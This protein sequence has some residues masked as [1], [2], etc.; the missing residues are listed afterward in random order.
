MRRALAGG[1]FAAA[2]AVAF[3]PWPLR[4]LA[5]FGALHP[6]GARWVKSDGTAQQL[7]HMERW[8][9]SWATGA[10]G[11]A[12]LM[13]LVSYSLPLDPNRS[14]VLMP[15][16]YDDAAER[17]RVAALFQEYNSTRLTPALDAE[18]DRLA[19][20][21]VRR[22][23]LRYYLGLPLARAFTEWHPMPEY[24]LP[25][26][27]PWLGLPRLRAVYGGL[28]WMLF[29]LALAGGVVLYRRG[30]RVLVGV[31]G[32]AIAVRTALP[33]ITHPF[34]VER[35]LVEA[36]PALLL[37]SGAGADALSGRLLRRIPVGEGPPDEVQAVLPPK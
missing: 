6:E 22:A 21:R 18:F 19:S 1:A 31:V 30:E 29:A 34:P 32:L 16:M 4:N 14:G 27:V 13:L 10:P 36:F 37:L 3:A 35:Y 15:S 17:A 23:P 12:Y 11:E 8:M 9:R 24:E 7:N 26:K 20:D 25:V 28:E 33:A 5:R 2:L